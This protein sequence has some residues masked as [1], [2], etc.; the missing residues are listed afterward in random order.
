MAVNLRYLPGDG[1]LRFREV[2]NSDS[3]WYLCTLPACN[4]LQQ[5]PNQFEAAGRIRQT[6]YCYAECSRSQTRCSG[7][8]AR[9]LEHLF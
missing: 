2:F 5:D 8:L 6:S 7:A 9:K 4:D 1:R 3:H